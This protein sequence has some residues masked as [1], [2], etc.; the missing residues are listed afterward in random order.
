MA[1]HIPANIK[2][3]YNICTMSDQRRR[4]WADVVQLLCKS[5]A[6]AGVLHVSGA[7]L[8][9]KSCVP[10][11]SAYFTLY[12]SNHTGLTSTQIVSTVYSLKKILTHK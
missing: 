4:R 7:A 8:S 10:R 11:L 2:H 5:F 6:F 9:M 12:L 3:F 1:V